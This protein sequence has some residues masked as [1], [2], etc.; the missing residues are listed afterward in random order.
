MKKLGIIVVTCMSLAIAVI[1]AD[2]NKKKCV[3]KATSKYTAQMPIENRYRN[4]IKKYEK[5]PEIVQQEFKNYLG[6]NIYIDSIATKEAQIAELTSALASATSDVEELTLALTSASGDIDRLNQSLISAQATIEQLTQLLATERES[7][8]QTVSDYEAMITDIVE[9]WKNKNTLLQSELDKTIAACSAPTK[10]VNSSVVPKMDLSWTNIR[11]TGITVDKDNN[12]WVTD[13]EKYDIAKFDSNGNLLFRV[14]QKG[15]G[16]PGTFRRPM[17]ITVDNSNRVYVVDQLTNVV[18][19]FTSNGDYIDTLKT[20]ESTK[21]KFFNMPLG[22]AVDLNG[23]IYVIDQGQNVVGKAR[24]IVFDTNLNYL[25]E[26]ATTISEFFWDISIKGNT[27]LILSSLGVKKY[28]L[29][30]TLISTWGTPGSAPGQLNSAFGITIDDNGYILIS[31]RGNK[32]INVY[33]GNGMFI[34]SFGSPGSGDYQFLGPQRLTVSNGA[35]YISD[36]GNA[37]V[38]KYSW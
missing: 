38:Q 28:N 21:Y 5:Q 30:G 10:T 4:I 11:P 17:G 31:D 37:R 36:Y 19:R 22:V 26:F 25:R 1:N 32:R 29:S 27:L 13:Q 18:Q 34:Y 2:A 8:D 12:V 14:G 15:C 35:V 24:V 16:D 33:D 3:S 6:I 23:N 9:S 20:W 7:L